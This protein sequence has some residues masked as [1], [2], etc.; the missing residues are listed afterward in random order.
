MKNRSGFTPFEI[1]RPKGQ[2]AR[3]LTGF[4]LI[5]L[6][7]VISIIGLLASVVLVSLNAARAKAR[8]TKR[9]ADLAQIVKALE[10]YYDQYGVYP[11]FRASNTCGGVRNDWATSYCSDP[12]WLSTDSN[13][14]QFLPKP[15]LDPLNILSTIQP[16]QDTPWWEAYTYTYG[17]SANGQVYDLLTSL[18]SS[19]DRDRCDFKFWKSQA[20]WLD[21]ICWSSGVFPRA[22]QIY[23][24]K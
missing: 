19:G 17:V 23:S 11:P 15:P 18:E 16:G 21:S 9:K 1:A 7:V 10:L 5:E 6:L 14:L 24:V 12:N 20:V 3:F 2:R 4:T 22:D 13:F 8:D